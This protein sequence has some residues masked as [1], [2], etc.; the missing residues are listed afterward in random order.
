MIKLY[1]K[2]VETVYFISKREY[3]LDE[4]TL[5]PEQKEM[6]DNDELD[7]L[8]DDLELDNEIDLELVREKS[9]GSDTEVF[10]VEDE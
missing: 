1:Q 10:I 4:T 9:V 6:L 8:W 7:A 5:T 3:E 2:E